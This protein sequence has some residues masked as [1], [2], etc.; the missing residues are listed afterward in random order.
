MKLK[1]KLKKLTSGQTIVLGFLAVILLGTLLLTLPIANTQGVWTSPLD[2]LFTSTS[3]VCVTGLVVKD[4]GSYWNFFGQ[5]IVILLIQVGGLGVVSIVSTFTMFTGRKI[6][7]GQRSKLVD[8]ISAPQ[9]G[10][11]LKTL[12]FI[13]LMTLIFE[14]TGALLLLPSFIGRFGALKGIWY[15][16]FHSISA[17]CNAGFDLMGAEEPFSSLTSWSG[18]AYFN[19]VIMLLIICGGLGFF[20]Y[21][22]LIRNKFRFRRYSMQTKVILCITPVLIFLPAV[23]F[24]FREYSALPLGERTLVS[25]F[26]SVTTRTAGF[27]TADFSTLHDGSVLIMIVLMMIGGCPGSTAGG[28]KTTTFTVML[29]LMFSVY[30]RQSDVRLFKRRLEDETVR[31]ASAL[32]MLYVVLFVTCALLISFFEE[33]PLLTCA[34]ETASAVGT[35][36]LTLGITTGLGTGSRLL[37]I[38]LMFIGRV[39]GLTIIY[40]GISKKNVRSSVPTEKITI[41]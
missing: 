41:G 2:A 23:F 39:G 18:D 10:G 22:D 21:D 26:Q 35:A 15:S 24:F 17:F 37:L 27:N 1:F 34:F 20:T 28:M 12:R 32:L 36:G 29:A 7:L 38:L 8:A 30:R 11:V 33:L 5:L 6:G 40:A 31:S 4:T 9:M 3:A 19:I 14:G 13:L 25:L 16:V